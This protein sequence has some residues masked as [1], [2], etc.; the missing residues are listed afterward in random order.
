MSPH[1]S[2]ETQCFNSYTLTDSGSVPGDLLDCPRHN[3]IIIF[4]FVSVKSDVY[5][6]PLYLGWTT[7]S[8]AERSLPS[9][10]RLFPLVLMGT[11]R[12]VIHKG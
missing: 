5:A 7:P 1:T 12:A 10:L 9:V 3:F 4:D 8:D 6:H 11:Y 2:Q